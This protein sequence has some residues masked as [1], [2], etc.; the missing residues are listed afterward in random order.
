MSGRQEYKKWVLNALRNLGGQGTARQVT[1]W[2]KNNCAVPPNDHVK[3]VSKGES[4]FAKEVR[5][6][7]KDLFDAGLVTSPQWGL[8]QLA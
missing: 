6:A 2:I 8:W 1:M 5:W 7:R 3:T 4:F